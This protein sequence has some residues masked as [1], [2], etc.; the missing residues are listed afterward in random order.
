MA[1]SCKIHFKCKMR[2]ISS[3]IDNRY[4]ETTWT[5]EL[6]S[7]IWRSRFRTASC[8]DTL[9]QT[10]GD[11]PI[12]KTHHRHHQTVSCEPARAD[13]QRLARRQAA[14]RLSGLLQ[15]LQTGRSWDR[16]LE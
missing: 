9:P 2:R 12:S 11:T 7:T 4:E 13:V 1:G 8:I 6:S 16:E 3:W 15:D 14:K 5:S 10:P